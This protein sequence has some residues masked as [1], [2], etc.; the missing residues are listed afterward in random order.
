MVIIIEAAF[1]ILYQVILSVIFLSL[2]GDSV[3]HLSHYHC[4]IISLF[5]KCF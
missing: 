4:M 1:S 2:I 5:A 3:S